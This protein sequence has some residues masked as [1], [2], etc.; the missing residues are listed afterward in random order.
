MAEEKPAVFDRIILKYPDLK[1][2]LEYARSDVV[3]A[4]PS[5]NEATS[6][7]LRPSYDNSTLP[8]HGYVETGQVSAEEY[9]VICLLSAVIWNEPDYVSIC[10][11]LGHT[12][13]VWTPW[14]TKIQHMDVANRSN[15]DEI[16]CRIPRVFCL[17][18]PM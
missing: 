6:P 5:G 16:L 1:M 18:W 7:N 15:F 17:R 8:S 11:S 4:I 3:P 13:G 12:I 14:Q 9:D 2:L 10:D